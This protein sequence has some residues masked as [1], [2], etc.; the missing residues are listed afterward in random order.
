[1]QVAELQRALQAGETER[2]ALQEETARAQQLA[3]KHEADLRS[4]SNAY[5]TLE[6]VR[7][8]LTARPS[9]DALATHKG[10][11]GACKHSSLMRALQLESHL[12]MHPG[13]K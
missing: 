12:L 5:N 13:C 11:H 9:S 8:R 2:A 6:Q 7:W 4:L 1:M 3:E 10:R